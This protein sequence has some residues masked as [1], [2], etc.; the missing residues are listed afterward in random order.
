MKSQSMISDQH[1]ML[2]KEQ[3]GEDS[4]LSSF[5]HRNDE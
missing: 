2:V 4:M 5:G 1:Q 3:I